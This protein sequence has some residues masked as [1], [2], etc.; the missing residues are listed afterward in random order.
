M[1]KSIQLT[2]R[3]KVIDKKVY[4]CIKETGAKRLVD[5]C[6]TRVELAS[7]MAKKKE[8]M[9]M[10]EQAAARLANELAE[11]VKLDSA[12]AALGF[13]RKGKAVYKKIDGITIYDA[14]NK[15]IIDHYT[16][17]SSCPN[18]EV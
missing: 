13:C 1:L 16:H 6:D 5:P 2:E 8:E 17:E 10:H 15:P 12:I 9:A 11:L 14:N 4:A 18:K 3:Y 7:I